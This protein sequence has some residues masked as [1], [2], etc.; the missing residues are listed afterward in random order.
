MAGGG[1]VE[2]EMGTGITPGRALQGGGPEH[3]PLS[4]SA[5]LQA[6][7]ARVLCGWWGEADRIHVS[8]FSW[9]V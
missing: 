5:P 4:W 1:V 3:V 2:D 6:H 9:L 8:Q 7:I